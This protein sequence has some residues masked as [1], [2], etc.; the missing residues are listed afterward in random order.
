MKYISFLFACLF[1]I[2][3]AFANVDPATQE[4]RYCGP[5]KRDAKGNIIR[6]ADVLAAFQKIHP[7]P[8]TGST[9]G[10]CVDWAKDH[11]IPLACG[12]CDAVS[13]LQWLPV[14]MKA[15]AAQNG[16]LPKDRFERN[17]YTSTTPIADTAACK[18][19]VLPPVKPASAPQ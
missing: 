17:V 8:A 3:C 11:V 18:F 15:A 6:R 7:C 10:A 14:G 2:A 5:P 19:V 12:G 16:A 13:N 4:L 1:S 9:T